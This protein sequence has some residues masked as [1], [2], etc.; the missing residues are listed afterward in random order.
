MKVLEEVKMVPPEE[1]A[2][3]YPHQLSGGQRQRVVVAR[4]VVLE[5]EFIVADE[6]V[7]MLDASIRANILDLLEEFRVERG[8]TFLYITH[9]LATARYIG[10][11]IAIMY[12]GKIVEQGLVDDVLNPYHPYTKALVS[13]IPVPDPEYTRKKKRVEL[14]GE[15][16]TPINPPSGCRLHP[17][18][19]YAMD[20]CKREEPPTIE[21]EKGHL[22]SCWLYTKR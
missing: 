3:R 10:D 22:V 14:K 6:P 9:D 21:V 15:I 20:V 8:I 2:F 13:S 16:P 17:R 12:L 4:G 1:F 5:P 18:C 19:P 11:R 7:S